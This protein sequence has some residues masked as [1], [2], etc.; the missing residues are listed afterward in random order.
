MSQ[1]SDSGTVQVRRF[2]PE[3]ETSSFTV[4]LVIAAAALLFALVL[5]Q[6]ELYTYYGYIGPFQ[7]G[8]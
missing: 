2:A 4:M 6:V 8:G 7:T 1:T 3:E 5:A